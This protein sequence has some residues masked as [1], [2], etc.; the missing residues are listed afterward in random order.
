MWIKGYENMYQIS[1]LGRVKSFKTNKY[2][3]NKRVDGSGYAQ[4]ALRKDGKAKEFRVNRLVALHFIGEP[5]DKKMTVNHKNGYKLDNRADNLEWATL[6]EQ[7]THAYKHGLKKASKGCRVVDEDTQNEIKK[8]YQ[9]GKHGRSA[10]ALGKMFGIS[11]TT[12]ERIV[13]D[14]NDKH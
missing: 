6:S 8:L 10:S 4:V 3:S 7:M 9:K 12:V 2:L 5:E 13:R 1:D 11:P 14:Y